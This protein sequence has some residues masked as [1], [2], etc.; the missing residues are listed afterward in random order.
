MELDVLSKVRLRRIAQ[1][2]FLS[3][4][5]GCGASATAP[6]ARASAPTAEPPPAAVAAAEPSTPAAKPA[7]SQ[8]LLPAPEPAPPEAPPA[9]PL[10]LPSG[11]VASA[12]LSAEPQNLPE[13]TTIL[14]IGDSFAGALGLDLE[15]ALKEHHIKSLLRYTTSS[16]IPTWAY[17]K[18]LSGYLAQ[19]KPDLVLITLGGNELEID[20][21][22]QRAP[23][24]RKL[25]SR[26]GDRPCVW[27]APPLWKQSN[28]LLDVIRANLGSCRYLD[29]NA[30]VLHMPRAGDKIHPHMDARKDW[31]EVTLR[32]LALARDPAGSRPWELRAAEQLPGALAGGP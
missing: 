1:V 5:S 16:Y 18:K 28:G 13:G 26:I 32:W 23:T 22:E 29:T 24:V 20:D 10:K 27:V 4:A 14:H 30:L 8:D 19:F 21:P 15:K 25:I 3:L 17:S 31:A 9:E 12:A 7:K 11:L 6:A 2:A